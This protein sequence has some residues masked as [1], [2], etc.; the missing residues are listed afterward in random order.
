MNQEVL[1]GVP[2]VLEEVQNIFGE[3]LEVIEEVL[4]KIPGVLR[5]ITP[6][7]LVK[8]SVV[9]LVELRAAVMTSSRIN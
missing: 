7:L 4:G 8:C 6:G 9:V 3:V 5:V 1:V 2:G